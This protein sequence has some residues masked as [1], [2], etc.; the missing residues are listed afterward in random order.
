MTEKNYGMTFFDPGDAEEVFISVRLVE[1]LVALGI[2]L[3]GSQDIEVL[4]PLEVTK[5]LINALRE[6]SNPIDQTGEAD[7]GPPQS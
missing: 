6:C 5:Q 4:L 3:K 1:E 7:V 2:S